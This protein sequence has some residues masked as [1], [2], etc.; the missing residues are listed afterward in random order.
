M[1]KNNIHDSGTFEGEE[2]ILE[3]ENTVI[4]EPK[5]YIPSMKLILVIHVNRSR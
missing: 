2:K 3:G 4:V 5:H 1:E